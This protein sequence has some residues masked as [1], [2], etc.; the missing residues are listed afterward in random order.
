MALDEAKTALECLT[1]RMRSA[2][3]EYPGPFRTPNRRVVANWP[4]AGRGPVHG[5][6]VSAPG[7]HDSLFGPES[8]ILV[9]GIHSERIGSS[10]SIAV[11]SRLAIKS[12]AAETPRPSGS[13]KQHASELMPWPSPPFSVHVCKFTNPHGRGSNANYCKHP[14]LPA[15]RCVVEIVQAR[16]A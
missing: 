2:G 12:R 8:S 3:P 16:D 13:T 7:G 1:E 15:L 9:M 6:E 11:G 5:V 4:L 14:A 10:R